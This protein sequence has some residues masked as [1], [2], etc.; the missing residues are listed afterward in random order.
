MLKELVGHYLQN[1]NL[2]YPFGQVQ[3]TN[4][5]SRFHGAS[6]L[7]PWAQPPVADTVT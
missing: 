2:D 1:N 5:E 6:Q 4:L 3:L 7:Y